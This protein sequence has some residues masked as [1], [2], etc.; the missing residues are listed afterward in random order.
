MVSPNEW[1]AISAA[2]AVADRHEV[3]RLG[4]AAGQREPDESASRAQLGR[5]RG[6]QGKCRRCDRGA[7]ERAQDD[8]RNLRAAVRQARSDRS[9]R[10][11][12]RC[13]QRRQRD[14][15]DSFV[16]VA[17]L[18]RADREYAEHAGGESGGAL[19]G[20]FRPVRPHDLWRRWRRRRCGDSLAIDRQARA[21]AVDIAGGSGVVDCL[22]GMGLRY[23]GRFRCAMAI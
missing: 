3:D 6:K 12:C 1:E 8:L 4:R 17:G 13:A 22:A 23:E 5:A 14:G 20:T 11:G 15:L 9:L 10:C 16:A 2:R 19:A 18:A 21:R 7:G